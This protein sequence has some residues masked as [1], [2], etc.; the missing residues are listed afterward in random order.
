MHYSEA[1]EHTP[2]RLHTLFAD[3]YCAFKND[4]DERQLHIRIMLH[5]LLALPMHQARATLRVIH[6]WENGGFEPSDLKHKD[7]PLASLDDFHRVVNEVSSNPQEHET[8]LSANTSLLSAPLASV[9]AN[10]EAEG[11]IVSDTLRSTPSRWPALKGGL[12][13]YTLFKMYHRLVYGED[14]NYRCSQCETPD[15]LR[16]L[17]EFHLEEG[18]FALLVPHNAKT[19]TVTPTILVMHASQLGP[20]G[21]LLKR[22]LPLFQDT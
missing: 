3:P 2:G 15:G 22:S 1:K 12:A 5:I 18:E 9:F 4:T 11:S 21:Q 10:A 19:Q 13:I 16:E 6:G 7:F 20:I 8:S 17:H 14:D